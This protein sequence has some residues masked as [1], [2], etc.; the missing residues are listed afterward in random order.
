[1]EID[2]NADGVSCTSRFPVYLRGNPERFGRSAASII[3]SR[4]SQLLS[5]ASGTVREPNGRIRPDRL[6]TPFSGSR[7]RSTELQAG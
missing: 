7:R 2:V 5:L 3:S 6:E 1:M 4:T